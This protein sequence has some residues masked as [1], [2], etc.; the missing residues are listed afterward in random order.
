[1][2]GWVPLLHALVWVRVYGRG[3]ALPP[4][5]VQRAPSPPPASSSGPSSSPG[6]LT[7]RLS[8]CDTKRGGGGGE[9]GA[10]ARAGGAASPPPSRRQPPT[11]ACPTHLV[12]DKATA[13]GQV[14]GAPRASAMPYPATNKAELRVCSATTVSASLQK[15]AWRRDQRLRRACATRTHATPP[16]T[17]ST[18]RQAHPPARC[19]GGWGRGGGVRGSVRGR[20]VR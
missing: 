18:A 14:Q 11:A 4:A 5:A 10:S 1:M 6:R 19:L 8:T 15:A 12:T 13:W 3:H 16:V 17:N 20:V 2:R 9:G 7:G